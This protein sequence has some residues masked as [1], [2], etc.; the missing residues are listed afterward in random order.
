MPTTPPKKTKRTI[1]NMAKTGLNTPQ[2]TKIRKKN[3]PKKVK[4]ASKRPKETKKPP[5]KRRRR[6]LLR[7]VFSPLPALIFRHPVPL[8]KRE[9]RRSR[10]RKHDFVEI[11]KDDGIAVG[12]RKGAVRRGAGGGAGSGGRCV[13]VG[14][15]ERGGQRGSNGAGWKAAVAVLSEWGTTD[16]HCVAKKKKKKK[17]KQGLRAVTK[18]NTAGGAC[19]Y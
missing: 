10:L 4:I 19:V 8:Q 1:K 18:A 5:T 2:N 13:A 15:G 6:R 7:G 12:L 9:K 3:T 11:L 17:K 14:P 16:Y